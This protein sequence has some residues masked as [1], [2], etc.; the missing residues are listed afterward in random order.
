MPKRPP[1][2]Y[3]FNGVP[4]SSEEIHERWVERCRRS[5]EPLRAQGKRL[6]ARVQ[7]HVER[8]EKFGRPMR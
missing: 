2:G 3:T 4:T 1:G 8:Q 6:E 5:F 7:A